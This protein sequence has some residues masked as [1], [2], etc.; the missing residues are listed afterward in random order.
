MYL[1]NCPDDSGYSPA[2]MVFGADLALPGFIFHKPEDSTPEIIKC[3][4]EGIQ[5]YKKQPI[6]FESKVPRSLEKAE[7]VYIRKE[8]KRSLEVPY[9]G[10]YKIIH[11]EPKFFKLENGETVSVD[12]LKAAYPVFDTTLDLG[13]E[14][15]YVYNP[16]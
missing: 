8:V 16:I 12:R 5:E 7:Y 2:Q 4:S 9:S 15:C 13:G 1:R 10:P 3:I 14:N 11:K 6:V